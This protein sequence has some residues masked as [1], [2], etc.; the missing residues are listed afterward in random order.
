MSEDLLLAINHEAT[1]RMTSLVAPQA[2]E[3]HGPEMLRLSMGPLFEQARSALTSYCMNSFLT[4]P[5][6][7]FPRLSIWQRLCFSDGSPYWKPCMK[8]RVAVYEY[9]SL[10]MGSHCVSSGGVTG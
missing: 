9:F 7:L 1:R 10:A 8:A 5:V 4:C 2:S 3:Q 6:F